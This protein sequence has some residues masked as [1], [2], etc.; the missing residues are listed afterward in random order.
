MKRVLAFAAFGILTACAAAPDDAAS[1]TSAASS[2]CGARTGKRGATSRTLTVASLHRT[3]RVYLPATLDPTKPVP[4]VYVHHGYTMSSAEMVTITRYTDL[5]DQDGFAVVFPDGQGG[6]DSLDAPWNVGQNVCPSLYGDPP[7]ATGDDNA[8]LD[9][10]RADIAQDQCVDSAHVY[11]TGFSMGGYFAHEAGCTR[12][13]I[14]AVAPHSGGTHDLASCAGTKKP[15][16]MFH[17]DKDDVIPDGCDDP[18]AKDTP[19]GFTPAAT[20]WAK[21][22]GCG[23]TVHTEAVENGTCSYYDDCPLDAQVAICVM[24][25]MAHCWAGGAKE[26]SENGCPSYASATQL[27]WDF[28]KKYAW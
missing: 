12:S 8:F 21:R 7:N 28:F 2:T 24:H 14:R 11:L 9:A 19:H 13:D 16:I 26:S 3:Y 5:A 4:L 25:G 20:A 10:I 17:G 18:N 6:P 27:E 22:N 1:S 23:T 15:I